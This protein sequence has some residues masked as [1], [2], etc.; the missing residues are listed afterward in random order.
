MRRSGPVT[1]GGTP[2]P[3]NN[4]ARRSGPDSQGQQ[5]NRAILSYQVYPNPPMQAGASGID[6]TPNRPLSSRWTIQVGPPPQPAKRRQWPG[7][8]LSASSSIA[9][10]SRS[11]AE[12]SAA[13]AVGWQTKPD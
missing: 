9:V 13:Q 10:R 12:A 6:S 5:L 8:P 4:P 2:S 7:L 3:A 11:W 1:G